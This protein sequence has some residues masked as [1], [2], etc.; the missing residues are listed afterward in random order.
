MIETFCIYYGDQTTYKGDPFL[1]VPHNVVCVAVATT[2]GFKVW[3]SRDAYYW[4][5]E[6]GWQPCD[7]WGMRD[8]L[9]N[10]VGAKSVLFGRNV[11]DDVFWKIVERATKEGLG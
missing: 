9:L 11:R 1:V 2:E 7:D 8:Y 5:K 10:Y 6:S 4:H 3:H